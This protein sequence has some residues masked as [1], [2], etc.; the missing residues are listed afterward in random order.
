MVAINKIEKTHNFKFKFGSASFE[1]YEASGCGE[2][3]AH[4]VA[5]INHTFVIELKP[6]KSDTPESGFE[7]PENKI[8]ETGLEMYDGFIEY[9]KTFVT[10]NISQEV[11]SECKQKLQE[12][13]SELEGDDYEN[14]EEQVKQN[15]YF[16]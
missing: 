4:S 1:L 13:K 8:N 5:K 6:E 10:K 16:E 7:H 15:P 3:W 9:M 11:I 14:Y 2:D 12:M